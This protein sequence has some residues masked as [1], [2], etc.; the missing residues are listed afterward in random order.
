MIRLIPLLLALTGIVSLNVYADCDRGASGRC[1]ERYWGEANALPQERDALSRRAA[2]I[3]AEMQSLKYQLDILVP[4]IGNKNQQL[5]WLQQSRNQ[6]EKNRIIIEQVLNHQQYARPSF[7]NLAL[8]VKEQIPTLVSRLR[9][10]LSSRDSA[11]AA[12]IIEINTHLASE[13][14]NNRLALEY[15]RQT[16]TELQAFR[17]QYATEEEAK[18]AIT[19]ILNGQAAPNISISLETQA[20]LKAALTAAD[21][22]SGMNDLLLQLEE[23]LNTSRK[24][25]EQSI[26]SS[27]EQTRQYDVSIIQIQQELTSFNL[28]KQEI[29]AAIANLTQDLNVNI[30]NRIA[31]INARIERAWV[32]WHCCDNEPF[33][34]NANNP[35]AFEAQIEDTDR[36]L[37]SIRG[38]LFGHH[39]SV[40]GTCSKGGDF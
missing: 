31:T 26:Q 2:S 30:P 1:G 15:E 40:M 11:I 24:L 36:R 12:R 19:L 28:R 9:E 25:L 32:Y 27:A 34:H 4:N 8:I 22:Y 10:F 29:E 17:G 18:A 23:H 13:S 20:L 3:P 38:P 14:A 5:I 35:A 37:R 6:N 21:S 33:C 16:L 39:F 7:L